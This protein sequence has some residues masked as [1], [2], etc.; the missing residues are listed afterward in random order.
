MADNVESIKPGYTP[1][2]V[3]MLTELLRRA[4]AGEVAQVAI[5]ILAAE[6][7]AYSTWISDRGE[8][9][10]QHPTLALVGAVADLQFELLT[11]HNQRQ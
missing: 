9:A 3:P 11:L 10:I 5:V 4:Q 7:D 1:G 6:G 2:L 8:S